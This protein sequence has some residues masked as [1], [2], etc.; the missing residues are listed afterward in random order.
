M[1]DNTLKFWWYQ[2]NFAF[3]QFHFNSFLKFSRANVRVR[4]I[5]SLYTQFLASVH[6]P[7]LNND[8][9]I[10]DNE[11]LWFWQIC[12]LLNCVKMVMNGHIYC[13]NYLFT[14]LIDN[15][16]DFKDFK[17]PEAEKNHHWFTVYGIIIAPFFAFFA[18][19]V[20]G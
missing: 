17:T 16:K 20:S 5:Q 19:L 1:I 13:F 3:S 14:Q 18:F 11:D 4:T 10:R 6:N 12:I 2:Q 9:G 8:N 7:R 15:L